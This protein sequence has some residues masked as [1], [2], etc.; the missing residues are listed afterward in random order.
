MCTHN[1]VHREVLEEETL[2]TVAVSFEDLEVA[3][4]RDLTSD[5]SASEKKNQL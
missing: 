4:I 1:A 2:V 5:F 3:V